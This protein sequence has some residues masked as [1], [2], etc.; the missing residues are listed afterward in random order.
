MKKNQL[1][2]PGNGQRLFDVAVI[3]LLGILAGILPFAQY[4]YK[5]VVYTMS[6]L[7]FMTGK[8]V[9]GGKVTVAPNALVIM[10]AVLFA[11]LI[12]VSLIYPVFKG[13]KQGWI[14][15]IS[16]LVIIA[17]EAVFLMSVETILDG[18]K[19]AGV[20]IGPLICILLAAAVTARG[21][22]LLYE[23]KVVLTLDIMMIPGLVYMLINNYM[24]M[25]GI[26]LSF[27]KID[28]SVGIWASQWVGFSN[29]KYL[30]ST[31]DA[32]VI[33]R[34]TLLYNLVF[35]VLGNILG[36]VVGIALA[37]LMNKKLQKFYQT[38]IL[39]PQLISMIIVAYIVYGFLSNETGFINKAILGDQNSINFY[40]TQWYW[41]FIL[42]FV[43]IWKNIGYNGIIYLSSVVGIDRSLYEASYVDGAGRWAQ[44]KRITLPLL[45]P[46][47]ITLMILQV[48][49]I[50][51]SDFG[52]FY[53]VPM[54]SGALYPVTNTI[55]TYVYRSLMKLNNISMA[56]AASAFQ[57]VVGFIVVVAVNAL[58][59]KM[60]KD[61]ALF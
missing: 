1:K 36:A 11:L 38:T 7:E 39:L 30:F 25:P 35:I 16:G 41:P 13:R 57:S 2:L 31:S 42:T 53:Q 4:T 58:V 33:T 48:G 24:P 20:G 23:S 46:T 54:D 44:I 21:F 3:A 6:G 29:F 52:L 50:F 56:S 43:S 37:E 26:A 12:A 15:V 8:T 47:F 10:T 17:A 60:D 14:L 59:R 51:Y 5:K 32:F 61:N 40:S 9:Y 22:Y 49:R 28:F 55:D 45:K 18:A 19:K 34:N 27:K